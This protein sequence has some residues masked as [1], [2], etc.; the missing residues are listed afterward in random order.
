M[1]AYYAFRQH[2]ICDYDGEFG[3]ELISVL[4]FAYWLHTQGKLKQSISASD[5]KAYY[6]FSNNHV[7][8]YE[9]RR[10]VIPKKFPVHNIHVRFLNTMMWTPPPLKDYYQNDECVFDKPLLVICNKYNSEWGHPPITFLSKHCLEQLLSVLTP[11]YSVVYCRPYHKEFVEDNSEVYN[12]DEHSM[13]KEK[14]PDVMFIQDLKEQYPQYSFNELQCRV[15]ANADRFISVQGGY[16]ILCSYFKGE[17][18]I[19]GAQS[20]LRTADE[21]K[22]KAFKRWYHKFSGSKITYVPTYKDLLHQVDKQ[23][24][25]SLF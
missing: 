25:Q 4:P 2:V 10:Y 18:I 11:H 17:N 14:F 12:L 3:Y 13:I 24:V 23:Y 6:F 20:P 16:S 15:F 19:Y 21:I 5:T 8:K 7:E 22:Y 9:K 1:R